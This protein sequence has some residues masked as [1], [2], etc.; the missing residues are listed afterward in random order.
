MPA[1]AVYSSLAPPGFTQ[2]TWDELSDR[3]VFP[4][5][6]PSRRIFL[7]ERLQAF[8]TKIAGLGLE[9]EVWFNGSWNSTKPEPG[10]VD[11]LLV[12][13]RHEL[14]NMPLEQRGLFLSTVDTRPKIRAQ[15]ECDVNWV[16]DDEEA[17]LADWE[18]TFAFPLAPYGPEKGIFRLYLNRAN[19]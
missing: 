4:F 10:D 2:I 7:L 8:L 15:Y 6:N 1:P 18:N 11:L 19:D 17:M 16:T 14:V 13:R 5:V 3:F 9:T 12:F